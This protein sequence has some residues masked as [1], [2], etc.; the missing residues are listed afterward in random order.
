LLSS[1]S[2]ITSHLEEQT[3]ADSLGLLDTATEITKWKADALAADQKRGMNSNLQFAPVPVTKALKAEN[4]AKLYLL[5]QKKNITP[6]FEYA[7]LGLQSFN[8]TLKLHEKIFTPDGPFRSKKEAKEA[9]AK[10]GVE[11]LNGNPDLSGPSPKAGSRISGGPA[12]IAE[13]NTQAQK[14]K[15]TP[16]EYLFNEISKGQFSVFLVLGETTFEEQGPFQ[17]KKLAKESIAKLGLAHLQQ[18]CTPLTTGISSEKLAAKFQS[19]VVR[20]LVETP[21]FDIMELTGVM[22]LQYHARLSFDGETFQDKGPFMTKQEAKCAITKQALDYL[23]KKY[24]ENE[25]N[26]IG[27]LNLFSQAST[28][29]QPVYEDFKETS[30]RQDLWSSEVIIPQR[31]EPFGHRDLPFGSKKHARQN[32]AREAIQWLRARGLVTENSSLKKKQ[33]RNSSSASRPDSPKR[34]DISYAKQVNGKT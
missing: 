12:D 17:N 1:Q 31:A 14:L 20:Y 25:E 29:W 2:S 28:P 34:D 32:A 13:L 23:E 24:I 3:T 6:V 27:L 5:A 11:Y 18:V 16:P 15:I 22:P 21:I 10:L 9:A 7:D 4:V 33:K 26:W 30:T 8:A 19:F